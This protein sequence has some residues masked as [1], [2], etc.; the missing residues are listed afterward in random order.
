[1]RWIK[2]LSVRWPDREDQNFAPKKSPDLNPMQISCLGSNVRSLFKALSE[3]KYGCW[4]HWTDLTAE[5][6]GKLY[7][8]QSCPEL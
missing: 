1:M 8:E 3:A 4:S 6:I 7:A 2:L 5:N